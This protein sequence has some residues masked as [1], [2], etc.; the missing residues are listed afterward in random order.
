MSRPVRGL[1]GGRVI[2]PPPDPP[3]D[4]SR[5]ITQATRG[6]SAEATHA[7]PSVPLSGSTPRGWGPGLSPGTVFGCARL[8]GIL[9]AGSPSGSPAEPGIPGPLTRAG[10]TQ[11]TP[12]SKESGV[13]RV[14]PACLQ[15][16]AQSHG[17][18]KWGR[19]RR[20]SVPAPKHR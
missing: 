19:P 9:P 14:L 7:R 1:V 4:L 20:D 6:L 12:L 18:P 15:M 8:Y 13:E 11:T 3:R 5:R 16:E 2:N 10:L 17:C